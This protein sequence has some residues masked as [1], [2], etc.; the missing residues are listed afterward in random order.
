MGIEFAV[1]GAITGTISAI[2]TVKGWQAEMRKLIQ[3]CGEAGYTIQALYSDLLYRGS[4]LSIWAEYWGVQEDV[5]KRY[6]AG[7]W[8]EKHLHTILEYLTTIEKLFNKLKDNLYPFLLDSRAKDILLNGTGRQSRD[9]HLTGNRLSTLLRPGSTTRKDLSIRKIVDFAHSKSPVMLRDLKDL[10]ERILLL[11]NFTMTAFERQWTIDKITENDLESARITDFLS[12]I[13][14]SRKAS[15][16]LYQ[17]FCQMSQKIFS[18]SPGADSLDY[19]YIELDVAHS[20]DTLDIMKAALRLSLTLKYHFLLAWPSMPPKCPLQLSIHGPLTPD[21]SEKLYGVGPGEEGFISACNAALSSENITF[22]CDSEITFQ[23][24]AIPEDKKILGWRRNDVDT[25]DRVDK[26]LYDF[27]TLAYHSPI[28]EFPLQERIFLALKVS[29]CGLLLSGTSWFTRLDTTRIRRS[30]VQDKARRYVLQTEKPGEIAPEC[31]FQTI[32]GQIYNIGI[33]LV[34]IGTGH[35]VKGSLPSP[36]NQG[37]LEYLMESLTKNSRLSTWTEPNI[38]SELTASISEEYSGAAK[39]CLHPFRIS[40][41]LKTID[42]RSDDAHRKAC[43]D[44]LKDYYS[45]VYQP[46][47]GLSFLRSWRYVKLTIN[48]LCKLYNGHRLTGKP[49]KYMDL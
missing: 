22:R 34:E 38:Y 8:G 31:N 49:P 48:R 17:S 40:P 29:E 14:E 4:V 16:A 21:D 28:K 3:D 42:P 6:L 1:L 45:H 47:V 10:D 36:R 37:Q 7:L 12:L 11:K 41:H 26:V 18:A 23:S 19:V 33:I 15:T 2:N 35:I 43:L 44:L 9:R 32:A 46:Y 5:T 20:E 13:L 27:S 30:V 39:F 25:M 24:Q